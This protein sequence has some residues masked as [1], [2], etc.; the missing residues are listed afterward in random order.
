MNGNNKRPIAVLISD[1]HY[2]LNTLDLADKAFREAIDCAGQLHV[3]LIDCGDI[4]NDKAIIRAEVANQM[5]ETMKYAK[6]KR[7]DIF[8]LVGNHS[9]INEKDN[10]RH[11]LNFLEPF[12]CIVDQVKRDFILSF[13]PY[14]S[15][16]PSSLEMDLAYPIIMH[17]GVKGAFMG[18][19]IQDKSSVDPSLFAGFTVFSGHYHRHQQIVNGIPLKSH[20]GPVYGPNT[21]TYVGNPYTLS[22]GEANDPLK[23]FLILYSD[24]SFERV[25]LNYRRHVIHEMKLGD[26]LPKLRGEDLL[27]LKVEGPLS[28][29]KKINK[30]EWGE[31]ILGHSHFRLEIV[32]TDTPQP[33]FDVSKMTDHEIFD[34]IID[35]TGETSTQKAFLKSLWRELL[36]ADSKSVS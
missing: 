30:K 17:Q 9:L 14:A 10:T 12:C 5:I 3:P 8:L 13:M 28:E 16:F 23:G 22:F 18:D 35:A 6:D 15:E 34:T 29:L 27:L 25:V 7:V 20:E 33:K 2:S 4:T 36:D 19:Y 11:S 31:R 1:V 26:D 21:I 32:P 24:Y